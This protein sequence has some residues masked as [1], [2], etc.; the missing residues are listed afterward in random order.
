MK[1]KSLLTVVF[2]FSLI[3]VIAQELVFEHAMWQWVSASKISD[4]RLNTVAPHFP[5]PASVNFKM[6]PY[7]QE[8]QK[9]QKLFCFEYEALIN[10]PELTALNPYYTS[11]ED[12]IQMPYFIRP[13]SSYE[14]PQP[15]N[16]GNSFEDDLDHEL[17]IQAWYFVFHPDQ[18]YQ[19]YKIK[20]TFP[21]WFDLDAYRI[22]IIKKI[23]ETEKQIAL[24]NTEKN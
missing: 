8:I 14:K 12:I 5:K 23:D 7:D 1:I 10:A 17:D 9:W 6:E 15:K 13:L 2:S 11:Y 20:P 21:E 3:L 19:I 24:K 18:F 4:K 22:Q 16:T